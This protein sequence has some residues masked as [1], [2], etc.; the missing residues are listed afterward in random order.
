ML[1]NCV[2]CQFG[3]GDLEQKF[4]IFDVDIFTKKRLAFKLHQITGIE[5]GHESPNET[6]ACRL[7]HGLLIKIHKLERL[8]I[9]KIS[10]KA[11]DSSSIPIKSSMQTKVKEEP[12]NDEDKM[13]VISSVHSSAE[14]PDDNDGDTMK[15]PVISS[16]HSSAEEPPKEICVKEEI[17]DDIDEADTYIAAETFTFEQQQST[18]ATELIPVPDPRTGI[19]VVNSYIFFKFWF[20]FLMNLILGY[21]MVQK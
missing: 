18:T 2:V 1:S 5:F 16:V 17:L 8:I 15:M 19:K 9:A 7:C 4:S 3:I 10:N 20:N 14:E 13:P 6:N 12:S 21:K 11:A